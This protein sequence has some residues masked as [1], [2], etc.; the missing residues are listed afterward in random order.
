MHPIGCPN[1]PIGSAIFLH[2]PTKRNRSDLEGGIGLKKGE[3]WKK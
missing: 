2:D 1:S 3:L